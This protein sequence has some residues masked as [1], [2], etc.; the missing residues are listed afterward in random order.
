MI[1]ASEEECDYRKIQVIHLHIK[2]SQKSSQKNAKKIQSSKKHGKHISVANFLKRK[3]KGE[4]ER[5]K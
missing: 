4:K 1:E 2:V 5:L 3:T